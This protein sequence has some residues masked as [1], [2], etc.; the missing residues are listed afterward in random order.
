MNPPT[1]AVVN[2]TLY[3]IGTPFLTQPS[4]F[5]P[6]QVGFFLNGPVGSNYTVK[7]STDLSNWFNL[8]SLDATSSVMFLQDNQATNSQRFYRALKN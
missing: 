2:I 4:R 3:P 8:F 5:S 7:A 6:T 1:N